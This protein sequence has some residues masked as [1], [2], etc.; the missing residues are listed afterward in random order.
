MRGHLSTA[1]VVLLAGWAQV[2]RADA[3]S[4][5]VLG[6]EAVDV[7]DA[8]A[9]QLSES[10]RQR[11]AATAGIRLLPGKDL[12]EIKMIFGCDGEVPACMAQAGKSLGVDKLLYGSLKKAGRGGTHLNVT[13]KL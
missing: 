6:I 3:P 1:A 10:L 9:Q 2:A 8:L 4:V 5:A 12:I 13:L 7:P 11:L